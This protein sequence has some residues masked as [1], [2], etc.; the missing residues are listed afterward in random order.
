MDPR[1]QAPR[2]EAR[3]NSLCELRDA[4][5]TV[6]ALTHRAGRWP[7]PACGHCSGP[8]AER[9]RRA[10]SAAD[11]RLDGRER[12]VLDLIQT[13]LSGE[14]HSS[15]QQRR[16]EQA[17]VEFQFRVS[18]NERPHPGSRAAAGALDSATAATTAADDLLA[19]SSL[20][21]LAA[22][23]GRGVPDP[24]RVLEHPAAFRSR[25]ILPA[26]T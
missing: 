16:E 15:R 7:D 20:C 25:D 11:G 6:V 12:E 24:R 23:S 22:D 17:D 2:P 4:F 8:P 9:D 18:G 13:A 26:N 19:A 10:H 21:A 14:G 1:P 5:V 3:P